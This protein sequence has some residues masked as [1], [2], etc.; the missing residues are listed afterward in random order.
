MA[1]QVRG[2]SLEI[3]G[4]RV[5]APRLVPGSN[6]DAHFV[7]AILGNASVEAG[8]LLGL[9]VAQLSEAAYRSADAHAPVRLKAASRVAEEVP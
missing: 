8:P 5:D 6:P 7:A 4:K 1:A 3:D 2:Q 9:K